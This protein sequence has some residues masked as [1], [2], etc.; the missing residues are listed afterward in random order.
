MKKTSSMKYNNDFKYLYKKGISYASP[1]LVMYTKKC[2]LKGNLLGITV[3]KKQS[4]AVGRNR[5]RRIIKECYRLEEENIKSGYKIVIVARFKAFESDFK[6]IRSDM[7][8]LLKKSSL[9]TDAAGKN[10]QN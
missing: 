5:V 6:K 1:T 9:I 4:G 3:T 8:Y 2:N 10:N 7:H